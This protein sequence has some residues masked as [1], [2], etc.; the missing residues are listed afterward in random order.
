VP[1]EKQ[2]FSGKIAV[3]VANPMVRRALADAFRQ[4]GADTVI[5]VSDRE[6]LRLLLRSSTIDVLVADDNL[7]EQNTGELIADL[8]HGEVHE[9][10]FT[11]VVVLAH[12]Q[13]ERDLK[14]LLNC[15]PDAVVLTPVSVTD[16]FKKIDLLAAGRKPFVITRGYIG[17]DRRKEP[18][19]GSAQPLMVEPPNPLARGGD[20]TQFQGALTQAK[21][22]LK[23]ARVECSLGQL[24]WAMR[25]ENMS[26]FADLIPV[27]D[28]LVEAAP[29]AEVKAAAVGLA[30]A[31]RKEVAP[32]IMAW[33]QRL[34]VL[35]KRMAR[36]G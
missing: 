25:S 9:H 13:E 24:A 16:L 32:E 15:G 19:A 10:P 33:C 35:G 29:N 6:A 7:S 8:R 3:A 21:A 28:H 34:L 36:A 27:V 23:T 14:A 17:P 22:A 1:P 20:E 18:R 12:R 26:D 30:D 5:E 4:R 11:L 31:L 2:N